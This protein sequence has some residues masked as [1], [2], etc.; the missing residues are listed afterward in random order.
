MVSGRVSSLSMSINPPFP[1]MLNP[2]GRQTA[3]VGWDGT[4][5]YKVSPDGAKNKVDVK[6]STKESM[7]GGCLYLTA[8][9]AWQGEW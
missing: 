1:L 2:A 8:L 9:M 7:G 6:M 3:T 4:S 5:G